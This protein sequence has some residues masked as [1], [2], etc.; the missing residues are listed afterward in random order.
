M[1][2]L[3]QHVPLT[4]SEVSTVNWQ[5]VQNFIENNAVYILCQ[6]EDQHIHMSCCP[7]QAATAALLA[8]TE[9]QHIISTVLIP[10]QL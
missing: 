10:L 9:P 4:L 7:E 5:T 8:A 2:H 1:Q 3:R 6:L